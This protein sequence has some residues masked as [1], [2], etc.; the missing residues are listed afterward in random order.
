[1]GNEKIGTILNIVKFV[2]AILGVVLVA[3]VI[4][5]DPGSFNDLTMEQKE[6]FLNGGPMSGSMNYALGIILA[7]VILIL[8]FFVYSLMLDAKKALKSVIGYALAAALFFV[9]YGVVGGEMTPVALKDGIDESTVKAS[10][11]GLYLAIFA[12]AAGF[13]AMLISPLFRYLKN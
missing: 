7:G 11:A 9:F 12:I 8:G 13:V 10:E 6:E 2:L 4:G 1:M 5:S 3:W